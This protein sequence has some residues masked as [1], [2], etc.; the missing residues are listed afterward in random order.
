MTPAELKREAV[1]R[2]V[3]AKQKNEEQFKMFFTEL[4]KIEDDPYSPVKIADAFPGIRI[5]D[6]R[7]EGNTLRDMWPHYFIC[8]TDTSDPHF[9]DYQP[10]SPLYKKEFEEVVG[11]VKAVRARADEINKEAE[12]ICELQSKGVS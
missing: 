11:I 6:I 2:L 1:R 5:P 8:N 10:T 9:Q 4:Y 3:I 7:K 12:R